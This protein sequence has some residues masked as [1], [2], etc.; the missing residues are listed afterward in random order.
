[1]FHRFFQAFDSFSEFWKTWFG[2]FCQPVC[3][4]VASA[5]SDLEQ[6]LGSQAETEAGGSGKRTKS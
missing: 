6:D 3:S 2:Q 5:C 1:M 4:Q